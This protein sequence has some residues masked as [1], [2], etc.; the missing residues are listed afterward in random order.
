[1]TNQVVKELHEVFFV[2]DPAADIKQPPQA[3]RN[4]RQTVA[5]A[6]IAPQVGNPGSGLSNF[7]CQSA[8]FLNTILVQQVDLALQ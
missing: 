6:A 3:V 4:L 8:D 2:I 7:C 5:P 1:M